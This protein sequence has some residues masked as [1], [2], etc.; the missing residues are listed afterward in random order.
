[1]GYPIREPLFQISTKFDIS[2]NKDTDGLN[3][4]LTQEQAEQL[5]QFTESIKALTNDQSLKDDLT[6]WEQDDLSYWQD[7]SYRA[8]IKE[9][10]E[11]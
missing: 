8:I 3:G 2:S 9:I 4:R 1:M 5:Y 7:M 11:K 6:R 10:E